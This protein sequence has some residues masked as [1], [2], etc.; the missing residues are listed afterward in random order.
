MIKK[1]YKEIPIDE[2]TYKLLEERANELGL[3]VDSYVLQ[4][5]QTFVKRLKA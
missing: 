2:E 3:T 5:V 4:L 1:G